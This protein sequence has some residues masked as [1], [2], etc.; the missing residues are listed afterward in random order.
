VA[1]NSNSRT[2][3]SIDIPVATDML[4]SRYIARLSNYETSEEKI[5]AVG[6]T[7]NSVDY[8][9]INTDPY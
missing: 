6:T 7:D 3:K 8:Y 2:L 4:L 5:L 1:F 9:T